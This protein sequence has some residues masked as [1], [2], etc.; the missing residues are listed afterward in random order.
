MAGRSV[1][2]AATLLLVA[3]ACG[4]AA[5]RRSGEVGGK[6]TVFAAASL[7]DAF[8]QIGE[9]FEAGH[10]GTRVEFNF[11]GSSA[12][13]LQIE[14]GA[15]ADVFASADTAQV[16]RA[17]EA[18]LVDGA[19]RTFA[20]NM[21]VIVTPAANPGHVDSAAD[22]A[23]PGLKLVLANEQVPV[24]SYSLQV[25]RSMEAD[26]AYGA[27]FAARV[28]SNAVS[29]ESNV[30][31]VLAKVELGEADAGIV[32]T[33]DVTPSVAPHLAQVQVPPRFNVTAQYQL[34]L[35]KGAPNGP[36]ARAFIDFVLSPEGQQILRSYGFG[37]VS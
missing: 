15:R 22:L 28:L 27:G 20:R 26:P 10:P 13:R 6:V 7:T 21:L 29:F 3:A 8:N 14:Q 4:T 33:T 9:A 11:G 35:V 1:L 25:L 17:V 16:E 24:G 31:Q 2:L 34:A 18:G 19:P 30:K 36:T 5:P 32:Y 23:R 12:L 37:E